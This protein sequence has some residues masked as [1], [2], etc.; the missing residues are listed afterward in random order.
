MMGKI[1]IFLLC[2]FSFVSC[3]KGDTVIVQP[4]YESSNT[5]L[6]QFSKIELTD[7]ATVLYADVYNS[8]NNWIAISSKS[9]LQGDNGKV[10]KLLRSNGFDLDKQ[11]LM[12]E[13]GNKSFLLVFEPLDKNEKTV[14]YYEDIND[15]NNMFSIE[16]I[17]LY[18]VEHTEPIRCRLQGEV[19][20]RPQSS[21]LAL[22]KS[23]EDF[24]TVKVIFIPVRDGKF[25]YTFYSDAEEAWNLIFYDEIL[26]AAWRPVDFIAESGT[27]RFTLNNEE[28]WKKN[29]ISEG[30]CTTEYQNIIKKIQD[31][32]QPYHE[33]L[34]E[35]QSVLEKEGKYY[36]PEYEAI[37]EKIESL[38]N[39]DP[40]RRVH[41]EQIIKL[42]N[43]GMHLTSEAKALQE[44]YSNLHKTMIEDK[45]LEYA[46]ENPGIAGYTILEKIIRTGLQ[47]KQLEVQ[48]LHGFPQSDLPVAFSIF[49][50]IYEKEYP[51]HPY[52]ALINTYIRSDDVQVGKPC[53]DVT[54]LDA[55]GK[56]IKLSELIKG[57]VSLVHLWASWCGPCRRHGIEMIPVYEQYKNKG[58]TVV[59][60]ARERNREDM[61][62]PLEKDKYPWVN[63]LE[64]K[65]QNA[66]WTKF[67]IGNAGGGE[68]LVDA[69][70]NFLAVNTNTEEIKKILSEI[71]D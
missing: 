3:S 39:D 62:R 13:S 65:D 45:Q 57:K 44:A 53:P 34:S 35:K 41:I 23:G 48:G 51:N 28:D 32:S 54:A 19:I 33:V 15:K 10:Y 38:S 6:L 16:G 63:L 56:D 14:S 1:I 59:G 40:Q 71:L 20:N 60:I 4:E 26:R 11:V 22:L 25:D 31:N 21:R 55:D 17:K 70:G 5:E 49:H 46:K 27:I 69:E 37:R 30:K 47:Y 64:L 43:E 61:I 52:T 2:I 8:P 7:T 24:R 67:G 29:T 36:T 18:N 50:D 42:Q 9:V 12:P 68:F 58:F 66:I